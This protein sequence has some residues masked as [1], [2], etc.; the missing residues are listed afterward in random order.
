MPVASVAHHPRRGLRHA[1]V[2]AGEAINGWLTEWNTTQVPDDP[3]TLSAVAVA[4]SGTVRTSAPVT[5]M[6]KN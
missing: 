5:A 6:V 4:T 1:G 2:H 3:Y